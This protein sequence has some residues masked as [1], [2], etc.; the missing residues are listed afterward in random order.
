MAAH[1]L[2]VET[3]LAASRASSADRLRLRFAGQ[4]L[5]QHVLQDAVVSVVERLLRSVDANNS[6]ELSRLPTFHPNRN[7]PPGPKFL[8]HILDA[9]D[10]E[11]FFPSQ[12]EHFRI[13]A[14]KELQRQDAHPYEVRPVNPFVA[15][16]DHR[17]HAQQPRS[18]GRP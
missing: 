17:A 4:Q 12:L 16:R 2:D 14:G 10:L 13:F 18:L 7:L 15:L 3:R 1:S 11:Y 6:L 5:P 8:D 9:R